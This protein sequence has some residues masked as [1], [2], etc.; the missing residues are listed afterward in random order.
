MWLWRWSHQQSKGKHK[1]VQC[2]LAASVESTPQ[3]PPPAAGAFSQGH[4]II[5][6]TG[7]TSD[8]RAGLGRLRKTEAGPA[9]FSDH[10][11]VKRE[12][13]STKKSGKKTHRRLIHMLLKIND[14]MTKSRGSTS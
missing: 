12:I 13:K 10:D 11:A 1:G 2:T 4:R 3:H 5:S 7:P 8:C 9:I 6:G 14:V